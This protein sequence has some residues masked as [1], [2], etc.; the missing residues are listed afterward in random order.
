MEYE[1]CLVELNEI[2]RHLKDEDLKKI[3]YEIRKAINDKKD[4]YYNWS[5]DESKRLDEQNIDR[6]TIA[7]LSYLNMEYLLNKEQKSL[8][9]E[10]HRSNEKK[11]E[12]EKFQ[13]Y[14][15]KNIFQKNINNID[16]KEKT[17][18]VNYE[19]EIKVNENYSNIQMVIKKEEKWYK[20]IIKAI[21]TLKKIK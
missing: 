6:K 16:K 5:Y 7:M 21:A 18:E 9:E 1:K 14:N 4:N 12:K 20:K 17:N 3:P 19:K 11:I 2:L 13:K 10:L 15:L 8:M